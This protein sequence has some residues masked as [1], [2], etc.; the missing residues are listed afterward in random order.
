MCI[1]FYLSYY[2]SSY[3]LLFVSVGCVMVMPSGGL[4]L[5]DEVSLKCSLVPK[6]PSHE[7]YPHH[8]YSFCLHF[9]NHPYGYHDTLL[10]Q[11]PIFSRNSGRKS[12]VW[13]HSL[14]TTLVHRET[15]EYNNL[16]NCC[17]Q[18][19]CDND[20][21]CSNSFPVL[22]YSQGKHT[23]TVHNNWL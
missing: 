10:Y 23:S 13:H 17:T 5:E 8:L 11:W 18:Y 7:V 15:R 6:G 14:P 21:N 16:P 19:R 3:L 1:S 22:D 20:W 4:V 12:G 2:R 9:P